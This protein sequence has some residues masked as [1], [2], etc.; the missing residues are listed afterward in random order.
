MEERYIV[1]DDRSALR[2]ELQEIDMPIYVL[3]DTYANN[4]YVCFFTLGTLAQDYADK[5]NGHNRISR[6]LSGRQI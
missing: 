3:L 6:L 2:S 5:L 1:T 4:S